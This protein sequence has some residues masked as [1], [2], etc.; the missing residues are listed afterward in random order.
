MPLTVLSGKAGHTHI[1]THTWLQQCGRLS[2]AVEVV[3]G[4]RM[5]CSLRADAGALDRVLLVLQQG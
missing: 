5:E 1:L 3:K 2:H 4:G